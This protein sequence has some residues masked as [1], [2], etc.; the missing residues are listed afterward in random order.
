MSAIFGRPVG[1]HELKQ[2]TLLPIDFRRR[3]VEHY[4]KSTFGLR[5]Q[6]GPFAGMECV[7]VVE[8]SLLAPKILGTYEEELHPIFFAS[9][10]YR[11]FVDVGCAEGFYAVGVRLRAPSVEVHAFDTSAAAREA[12]AA[13]ARLNGVADAVRIGGLC[14]GDT[15][16]ELSVPGTLVLIDIEGAEVELLQQTP[17]QRLAASDVIVETH[18][19]GEALTT[20]RVVERLRPTHDVTVIAQSERRWS[21]FPELAVLGQ[22]DR[23]LALWEGRGGGQVWVYAR[24]RQRAAAG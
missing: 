9:D 21:A 11:R 12:T 14:S 13:M 7:D 4:L 16:A 6:T 10:A 23:F 20:A 17:M 24:S 18:Q 15:L 5:V 3:Y 2:S 1:T 19:V 22:L 8:G